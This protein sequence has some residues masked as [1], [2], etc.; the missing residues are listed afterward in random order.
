MTENSTIEKTMCRICN[1]ECAFE[2]ERVSFDTLYG[3]ISVPEQFMECP[4]FR[5]IATYQPNLL[6]YEM[7]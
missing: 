3:K 2:G 4:E 7:L 6:H 1:K 5:Q